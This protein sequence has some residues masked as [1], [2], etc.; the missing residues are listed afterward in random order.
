[1]EPPRLAELVSHLQAEARALG[2]A[3]DSRNATAT[4][5]QPV[6]ISEVQ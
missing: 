3:L 4:H 5:G 6:P 2:Q 1:M